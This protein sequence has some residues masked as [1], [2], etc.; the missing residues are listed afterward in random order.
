VPVSRLSLGSGGADQ[1][2]VISVQ[3]VVTS[4]PN[5]VGTSGQLPR[6]DRTVAWPTH[7]R[8]ASG[9][10]QWLGTLREGR[11]SVHNLT[12]ETGQ[13]TSYCALSNPHVRSRLTH[14]F[15]VGRV[16]RFVN[17]FTV[18]H[19]AELGR[20]SPLPAP[21]LERA[22]MNSAPTE[23]I[24]LSLLSVTASSDVTELSNRSAS[25]PDSNIESTGPLEQILSHLGRRHADVRVTEAFQGTPQ[26]SDET[27]HVRPG[28]NAVSSKSLLPGRSFRVPFTR[29]TRG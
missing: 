11:R 12:R 13:P 25:Q 6:M 15:A 3:K 8:R 10:R 9:C 23:S 2:T 29:R 21:Y 22:E 16:G 4:N 28:R 7:A 18:R 5:Q 17:I 19:C 14:Q 26:D 1:P 27:A 24:A 20:G